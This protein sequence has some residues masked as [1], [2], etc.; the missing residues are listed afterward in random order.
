MTGLHDQLMTKIQ[1]LET[2]NDDLKDE[3]QNLVEKCRELEWTKD[4]EAKQLNKTIQKLRA[5][6]D[7]S[8]LSQISNIEQIKDDVASR[9]KAELTAKNK[10]LQRLEGIY[11]DR[12]DSLQAEVSKLHV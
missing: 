1:K 12:I 7:Q 3:R 6:I 11:Q 8:K 4:Q 5:D 10:E 9:Y 2:E